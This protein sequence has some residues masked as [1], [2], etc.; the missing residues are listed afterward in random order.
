[1]G[2]AR[3]ATVATGRIVAVGMTRAA[4]PDPELAAALR[5]IREERGIT[6]EELAARCG[7]AADTLAEIEL[8]LVVA[9]WDTVRRLAREL[10]IGLA[11][12]GAMIDT[13]ADADAA[14]HQGARKRYE[15]TRKAPRR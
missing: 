13:E 3:A 10:G 12:L 5:V 7:I 11:E 4:T 14:P 1:M 8:A 6:R 15:L 2:P 9:G